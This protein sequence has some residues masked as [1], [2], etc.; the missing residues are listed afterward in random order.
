[1]TAKAKDTITLTID[2]NNHDKL[3]DL[4]REMQ[5]TARGK[6][7]ITFDDALDFLHKLPKDKKAIEQYVLDLIGKKE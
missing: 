7:R 6:R 3:T 2:Y 1:M 5:R 4:K